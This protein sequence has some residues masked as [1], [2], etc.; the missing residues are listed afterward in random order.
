MIISNVI[1]TDRLLT[2]NGFAVV[3]SF[4][5]VNGL[6]VSSNIMVT[7]NIMRAHIRRKRSVQGVVDRRRL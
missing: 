3:D 6:Y 2:A 7:N 4:G 5:S 1:P